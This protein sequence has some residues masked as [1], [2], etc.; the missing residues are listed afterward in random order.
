M[1]SY[2]LVL[3]KDLNMKQ[4]TGAIDLA[5]KIDLLR[6]KELKTKI[7]DITVIVPDKEILDALENGSS[8][9]F[10]GN[11]GGKHFTAKTSKK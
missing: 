1:R 3:E 9:C 8:F 11:C 6:N 10:L 7:K 5:R 2:K 4:R